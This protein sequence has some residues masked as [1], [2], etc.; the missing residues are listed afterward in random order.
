M[1][2]QDDAKVETGLVKDFLPKVCGK[3]CGAQGKPV[4]FFDKMKYAN[5]KDHLRVLVVPGDLNALK[6]AILKIEGNYDG[7]VSGEK[8]SVCR[9]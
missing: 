2:A 7:A 8:V 1:L 9:R 6:A 5:A 3:A 4:K